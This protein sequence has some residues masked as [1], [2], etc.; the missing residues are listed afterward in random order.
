MTKYAIHKALNIE[1]GLKSIFVA[2]LVVVLNFCILINN[3]LT[4][5]QKFKT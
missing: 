4:P 1:A 2:K 5:V 3:K